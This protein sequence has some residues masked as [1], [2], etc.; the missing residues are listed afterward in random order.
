M[1]RW[2]RWW[3]GRSDTSLLVQTSKVTICANYLQ[4]LNH[5]DS[6]SA[7]TSSRALSTSPLMQIIS[8]LDSE[9]FLQHQHW[10]VLMGAAKVTPNMFY[11]EQYF[12]QFSNVMM[13]TLE[14]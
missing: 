13:A 8:L 4:H 9:I 11:S 1:R 6:G 14:M 3:R 10:L 12:L 7:R 5:A 2:E